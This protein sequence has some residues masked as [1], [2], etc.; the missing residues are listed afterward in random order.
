MIYHMKV[1]M[2]GYN[3]GTQKI[4]KSKMHILTISEPMSMKP[5][6][7]DWCKIGFF[8]KK[9]ILNVENLIIDLW[10][11]LMIVHYYLV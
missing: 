10:T 8:F 5:A 4:W 2:F 11:T 3:L 1:N 9:K 7:V 6:I